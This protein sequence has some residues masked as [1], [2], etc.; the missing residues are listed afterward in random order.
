[1]QVILFF[2]TTILMGAGIFLLILPLLLLGALAGA[3][4]PPN[5]NPTWRQRLNSFLIIIALNFAFLFI[6]YML[7]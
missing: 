1:M 3:C 6:M 7:S 4:T 5:Y 2:S